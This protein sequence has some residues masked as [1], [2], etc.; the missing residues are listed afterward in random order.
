MQNEPGN[1]NT[2]IIIRNAVELMG[3]SA[4][5]A[6]KTAGKDFVEIKALYGEEVKQLGE[7]MKNYGVEN[8]KS[9]FDRDGE[10]VKKSSA[11]LLI[12]LKNAK[13]AGLNCGAC[14]FDNC[15]DCQEHAGPEYDGPQCA[16]RILDMGIAIGSA[17]KM[18]GILSIDN[19]IMYRAGVVA[20]KMGLI[21]ASF[22][23]G[24]PFSATGKNIY[25]DR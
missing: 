16:F 12:G 3:L 11:V 9:N 17:A 21:N 10:N 1:F 22:V 14:G 20:K 6:P 8:N 13:T 25:F 7:E 15:A 24:I 5:T 4:R 23:M 2:E 18:A 19:R